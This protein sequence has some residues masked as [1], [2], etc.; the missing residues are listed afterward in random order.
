MQSQAVYFGQQ[1]LTHGS[2]GVREIRR[3]LSNQK[4]ERKTE[5]ERRVIL[6]NIKKSKEQRHCEE[7]NKIQQLERFKLLYRKKVVTRNAY[8]GRGGEILQ[9]IVCICKDCYSRIIKPF[10]HGAYFS[11]IPVKK[12][13]GKLLIFH[14]GKFRLVEDVFYGEVRPR[15]EFNYSKLPDNY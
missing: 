14:E 10:Y 5:K 13:N 6:K 4:N 1:L 9:E 11:R 8:D 2:I 15:I 3:I 12:R 7:C